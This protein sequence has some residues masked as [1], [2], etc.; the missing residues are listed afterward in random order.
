MYWRKVDLGSYS[1]QAAMRAFSRAT[2]QH[3]SFFPTLGQ[4]G[5]LLD[6]EAKVQ[7]PDYTMPALTGGA[8]SEYETKRARGKKALAGILIGL[9]TPEGIQ[10]LKGC[11]CTE[12]LID[13]AGG[14]EVPSDN[15]GEV[16]AEALTDRD[17]K[18]AAAG[19]S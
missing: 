7:D 11:R 6:S 4:L 17:W 5:Q 15:A 8:P 12:E 2:V 18:M 10:K 14:L 1:E 16:L 13:M 9:K 3:P 19:E